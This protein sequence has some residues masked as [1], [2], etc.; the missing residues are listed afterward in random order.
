M[1]NS[2]RDLDQPVVVANRITAAGTLDEVR[3]LLERHDRYLRR[4]SDFEHRL[5]LRVDGS[6]VDGPAVDGPAVD[7]PAEVVHWQFE[8]W[9]RLGGLVAAAHD[10]GY[11]RHVGE[12]GRRITVEADRT[13]R[14]DRARGT[15]ILTEGP[16]FAVVTN[17]VVGGDSTVFESRE[18]DLAARCQRDNDFGGR[19]LLRSLIRPDRYLALSWWRTRTAWE[20]TQRRT[21]YRA[22]FAQ[23]AYVAGVRVTPSLDVVPA[24]S[25]AAAIEPGAE[26]SG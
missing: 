1:A 4:L 23:V 18:R 16:P 17:Y 24:P 20:R 5:R 13:V 22:A 2:E 25:G 10:D 21:D 7:G 6:A 12:L 14:V 11:L 9:R 19:D 3:L 8:Y 26:P 15:S